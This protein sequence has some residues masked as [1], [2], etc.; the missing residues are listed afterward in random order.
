[1]PHHVTQRGN[2]RQ[3]VFFSAADYRAYVGLMREWSRRHRLRGWASCLMPNHV[4]L[5]V[6]PRSQDGLCRGVGE[7][8]RRYTRGHWGQVLNSD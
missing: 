5:I 7:A 4:H 6:V 3:R 1:M 2:R 8:H